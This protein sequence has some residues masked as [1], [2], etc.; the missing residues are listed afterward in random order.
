[1]LR[2]VYDAGESDQA[3]VT[4]ALDHRAGLPL[5]GEDAA[6]AAPTGAAPQLI[7]VID[8]EVHRDGAVDLVTADAPNTALSW[9]RFLLEPGIHE[10]RV[11]LT[12]SSEEPARILFDRVVTLAAGEA[13][14][15]EYRDQ[16]VVIASDAGREVFNNGARG[17]R[18]GCAVCHSLEPGVD[19]IGPSL[20]G[21]A[22]RAAATVPG[23]DAAAYLRQSVVDPDAYIVPGFP[24][25]QMLPDFASVLGDDQIEHLVAFLLT[26]EDG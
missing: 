12:D 26:L 14:L 19:L 10:I 5:V 17:A 3:A 4:V 13:L 24:A 1:V 6:E 20:A 15:L 18:T 2:A 7:V 22:T 9:D 23:L 11:E 21:V 8:G 16:E 25:G